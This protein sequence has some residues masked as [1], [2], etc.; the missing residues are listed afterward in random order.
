MGKCAHCGAKLT[1]GMRWC[2]QCYTPIGENLE[3]GVP[4]K[5]PWAG[6]LKVV[7]GFPPRRTDERI[8]VVP[9]V[10]KPT[11]LRA[12]PTTFGIVGKLVIT[13]LVAAAGAGAGWVA[14]LWVE[15][16]DVMGLAFVFFV[17]GLYSIVAFIVLRSVWTAER[18]MRPTRVRRE[19]IVYL[20]AP[21]TPSAE[22]A[23][24]EPEE[25]VRQEPSVR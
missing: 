23:P 16:G 8:V 25:P 21:A 12:G 10:A 14:G 18:P 6:D 15:I 24:P 1:P 11:I 3:P 5:E 22:G 20:G 2:W 19:R 4:E 9:D 17:I 7:P 13:L